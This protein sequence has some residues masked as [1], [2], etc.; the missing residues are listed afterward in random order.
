MRPERSINLS[1]SWT[2]LENQIDCPKFRPTYEA[3]DN[4]QSSLADILSSGAILGALD[5]KFEH[6]QLTFV[7]SGILMNFG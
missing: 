2:V 1:F 7:Q 6:N 4:F 3:D 5:A